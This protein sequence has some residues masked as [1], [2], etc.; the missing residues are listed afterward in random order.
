M[1][2]GVVKPMRLVFFAV[3][4]PVARFAFSSFMA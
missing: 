3:V 4:R 2:A 1:I